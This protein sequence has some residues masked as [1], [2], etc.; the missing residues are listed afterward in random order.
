MESLCD[1]TKTPFARSRSDPTFDK[2]WRLK[3]CNSVTGIAER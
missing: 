3:L 1:H 2:A